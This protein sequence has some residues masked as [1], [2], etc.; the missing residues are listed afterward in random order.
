MIRSQHV[1]ILMLSLVS[2]SRLLGK[3]L[4]KDKP[5]DV[6]KTPRKFP[7]HDFKAEGRGKLD[8]VLDSSRDFPK[9]HSKAHEKVQAI[10]LSYNKRA[11]CDWPTGV[12]TYIYDPCPPGKERC[13]QN[14]DG[15][16]LSTNHCCCNKQDT[17]EGQTSFCFQSVY[18][19]ATTGD[20]IPTHF[21]SGDPSL[22]FI[23]ANREKLT[24][25][26]PGF[27][28]EHQEF[29]Y[30]IPLSHEIT[31]CVSLSEIDE[32]HL[33]HSGDGIEVQSIST[34]VTI[35]DQ[36]EYQPLTSDP[37]LNK[38]LGLHWY[39]SARLTWAVEDTPSCGYGEPSCECNATAKSC[40]FNLVID[41][42]RTFASYQK[43]SVNNETK[44]ALRAA[45][46]VV[47]SFGDDGIPV[48]LTN[49]KTCSE[50]K[51]SNCTE[52]PFVD[53]KTYRLGIAVNG[54]IPGPTLII[55]EG[56]EVL[57]R[58]HNE[59]TSEGISI[60]WHG[61]HQKG[62]PWMDG[63]GQVTQCPIGPS[64]SFSY[65]YIARPSGTFWYHSHSGAQRTDGL[66]GALIVKENPR[67]LPN[68][69]KVLGDFEDL[70]GEHTLNLID[71]QHEMSLD[72][73]TQAIGGLGFYPDKPLGEVPTPDDEKYTS[74]VSFDNA[75]IG[76][77]PYFSGLINGKGRHSD[78]EYKK[79][80]LSIFTVEEG[81]IYRF[82]LVGAQGMYAYK[83]S[84]ADHKLTVVATDGY[85][86]NPIKDV[87]YI[88]LHTGERYDFLLHACNPW[89]ES[90]IN[91]LMQVETM[92]SDNTADGPPYPS[93][94]HFGEAILHYK[95]SD[96]SHDPDINVPSSIYKS[97]VKQF[98]P[99]KCDAVNQC[100]AVNCPFLHF[101]SSYHIT[102]VNV[103]EMLLLEPTPPAELPKR[104][105]DSD[106]KNCSYIIN[107]NF[108]GESGT[109]SA[110]GRNFILPAFPPQ[111]QNK[112]FYANDGK[113][114]LAINCNPPTPEC[115]CAQVIDIPAKETIQLVFTNAG[116]ARGVHPIH[117]HGHSFHVVYV[118]YPEYNET[119]GFIEN[120]TSDI[121]CEDAE[122]T[123]PGCDPKACTRPR[124]AN[125]GP[126]E[127][128]AI[129][130]KTV[131][132]DT[133]QVPAGGYVVVNYLS[134]NP[135]YWFLHC[136]N[137]LHQ[138][139]GM[140][141]IVKEGDYQKNHPKT[142]NKCGD[143][144][145]SENEFLDF[146]FSSTFQKK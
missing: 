69:T 25:E 78:V 106:C 53:G 19:Q 13:P 24:F 74:T 38:M 8:D 15:C 63:V 80:R 90:K 82:R 23:L 89:P 119:T 22:V 12:C 17:G 11:T 104:E 145:I 41:E 3:H 131:R 61:I 71:W 87:D 135:G 60:H 1:L 140:A 103:N 77:V 70:P 138:L 85:F 68:I 29:V 57:I 111:T 97:I 9:H 37:H 66:Y 107:F 76:P 146:Y 86:V 20:K 14:D 93:L 26:L 110:N 42:I 2:A 99:R 7:K 118:G 120:V 84:I 46:G 142:M 5:K 117:V 127:G 81:K 143:F 33:E 75:R 67:R 105:P 98:I 94:G 136:H 126:P 47:F 51:N 113:C 134:D 144:E 95:Q 122:C 48:P 55:H 65:R 31:S 39:K 102:C 91:Y 130:P 96:D 123:N 116:N 44:I 34:S 121:H 43:L 72:L 36:T 21:S 27:L 88:I 124:W 139:Q 109:A 28:I 132:K 100:K 108:E 137:E 79:S 18:V 49:N 125:G 35:G 115:S 4:I 50:Y 112:Q 6:L 129:H 32:I 16:S 59:L 52:P 114:D 92:E 58:V 45:K 62:T 128:I 30:E 10:T 64:S 40:T 141:L 54:Q 83:F 133:V 56:Q 73:L 101:H